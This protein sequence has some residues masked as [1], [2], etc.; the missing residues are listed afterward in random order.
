MTALAANASSKPR[1]RIRS[2][3]FSD[4][5]SMKKRMEQDKTGGG[6]FHAKWG[7]PKLSAREL[8]T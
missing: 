2:R 8:M 1:S 4:L 7:F 6:A 5:P 3:S